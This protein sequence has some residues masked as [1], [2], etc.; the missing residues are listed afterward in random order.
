MTSDEGDKK[1]KP[2]VKE[3]QPFQA[4]KKSPSQDERSIWERITHPFEKEPDSE[5]SVEK[6]PEQKKPEDREPEVKKPQAKP[7]KEK[8]QEEKPDQKK[9]E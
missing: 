7:L 3:Q 6:K 8:D 4:D 5:K 1:K 2:E 9:P